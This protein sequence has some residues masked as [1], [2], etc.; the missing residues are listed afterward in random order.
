MYKQRRPGSVSPPEVQLQRAV[1]VQRS[2]EHEE[3]KKGLAAGAECPGCEM[4]HES[5]ARSI[6]VEIV[7]A[8]GGVEDVLTRTG[9]KE[10]LA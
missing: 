1:T 2:I 10:H 7:L 4:T 8:E 6:E 3:R 9:E 5:A